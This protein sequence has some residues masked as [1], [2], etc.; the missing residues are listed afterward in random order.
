MWG[1]RKRGS[2]QSKR[3]S[4]F[5]GYCDT[6]VRFSLTTVLNLIQFLENVNG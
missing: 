2:R 3:I 1:Q 6:H 4:G 5:L